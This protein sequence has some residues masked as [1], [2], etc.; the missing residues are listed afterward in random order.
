MNIA[1]IGVGLMGGL[2]AE[3]LAQQNHK[4]KIYNRTK[5]KAEKLQ[6]SNIT[7][8]DSPDEAVLE[9][10]IIITMLTNYNAVNEI[11]SQIKNDLSNKTFFQMGTLKP[12]EN[13]KLKKHFND[14]NCEY[15]EAPVLGSIPQV[16]TKSLITIVG[17]SKK[18]FDKWCQFLK[19]FG[20]KVVYAGEVGKAS[21]LKLALNQLIVTPA[22]AFSMSLGFV[23]ENNIDVEL[24]MDILRNSPLYSQNYDKKLKNYLNDEYANPNFP[25]KHL[26]KD[27]GLMREAFEESNIDN[28]VLNEILKL[29]Q[30]GINE[31]FGEF[32]YSSLYKTIHK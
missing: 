5:E 17:G 13:I 18:N 26:L 7:I 4:L 16:K 23:R 10:D 12:S 14:N 20:E 31:G 19:G 24:F 30:K 1:F 21:A 29:L 8:C 27:V 32:D 3:N 22:V 6:K 15:I 25:L 28:H 9:S 11:I 2:M